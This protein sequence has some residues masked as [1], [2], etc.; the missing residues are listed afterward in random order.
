M[1]GG[2]GVFTR[3]VSALVYR[4]VVGGGGVFTRGVS[5]LV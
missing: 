4:C 3:R 1:V 2:G 5:A